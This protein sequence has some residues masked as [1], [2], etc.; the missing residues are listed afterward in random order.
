MAVFKC[1]LAVVERSDLVAAF[2]TEEGRAYLRQRAYFRILDDDGELE[3]EEVQRPR[4]AEDRASRRSGDSR[5]MR[6]DGSPRRA[7]KRLVRSF[8]DSLISQMYKQIVRQAVTHNILWCRCRQ[9]LHGLCD[10]T[11]VRQKILRA[12]ETLNKK[13]ALDRT[14]PELALVIAVLRQAKDFCRQYVHEWPESAWNDFGHHVRVDRIKKGS[15]V[16]DTKGKAV[17]FYILVRG[18]AAVLAQSTQEE[19]KPTRRRSRR[20]LPRTWSTPR[21]RRTPS[22]K[23][24]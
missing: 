5:A 16:F 8:S 6:G 20:D 2:K 13:N 17:R 4:T 12:L 15:A 18:T 23:E 9:E 11:R 19:V 1:T 10:A 14:M 7:F 24:N 21:Q 22:G 3:A